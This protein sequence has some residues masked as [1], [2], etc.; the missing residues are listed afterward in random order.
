MPCGVQNDFV[1][2]MAMHLVRLRKTEKEKRQQLYGTIDV[3]DEEPSSDEDDEYLGRA[4]RPA[5]R[6][7]LFH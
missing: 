3:P 6:R 7:R 5:K 4:S 2:H 1:K